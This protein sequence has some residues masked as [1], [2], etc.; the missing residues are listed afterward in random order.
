ML[1][2][3][4]TELINGIEDELDGQRLRIE[5]GEVDAVPF[6]AR[7]DGSRPVQLFT[8]WYGFSLTYPGCEI[9]SV[10]AR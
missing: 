4:T 7:S 1:L 2:G 3:F 8:R 10:D 6:A 5:I 9:Y